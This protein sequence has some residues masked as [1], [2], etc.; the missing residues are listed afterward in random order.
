MGWLN[1]THVSSRISQNKLFQFVFLMRNVFFNRK[2]NYHYGQQAEDIQLKRIFQKK[3]TGFYIDV[4][5]FH[6]MKYNNTYF[7]YKKGWTGINIDLDE[8]K[9]HAF[10]WF[11]KKDT[12]VVNAVSTKK[13]ET[14]YWTNGFYSLDNTLE[15]DQLKSSKSYVEKKIAAD[16]LTNIIDNTEYR[17]R[18]IDL[19]CIDA[20]GHDFAVLQSLDFERY[21]P[22][23]IV[24]EST[25]ETLAKAENEETYKYL[26]SKDY[27]LINWVGISLVFKKNNWSC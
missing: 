16:T 21:Q 14:S 17:N 26:K 27:D 6:P 3:K 22:K 15:Y 1:Y 10:D 8:I 25:S 2:T 9:I 4:G 23:V 20:E 11:R 7:L 5:C 24:V 13:G 18:E 12:N 19:L